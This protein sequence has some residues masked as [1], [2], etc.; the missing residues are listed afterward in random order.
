MVQCI[1]LVMLL[2]AKRQVLCLTGVTPSTVSESSNP[3][4]DNKYL[5]LLRCIQIFK[6]GKAVNMLL[7][8]LLYRLG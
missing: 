5:W 8:I 3:R 4:P 7:N 2:S 1:L 6:M